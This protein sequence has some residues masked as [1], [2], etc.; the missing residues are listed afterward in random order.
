[1]DKKVIKLTDLSTCTGCSACADVCPKQCI[2]FTTLDTLHYYPQINQDEC[3]RC[4]KCMTSCPDLNPLEA[5]NIASQHFYAAWHKKELDRALSTSGGAGTAL[6]QFASQ[7]GWKICGSIFDDNWELAH[8]IGDSKQFLS[9]LR[10]SKYLQSRTNGIII[11]I[12]NLL[13]SGE[14]VL[15]FGT[16]CQVAA[17]QKVCGNPANLVTVEI[18]CHGVNSPIVWKDYV[19]YLENR[20]HAKLISYNF[21]DKTNGWERPKGGPNLTVSMQF[22][23]G[24]TIIKRATYNLFHYW[25]GQHYMLRQA[26]FNCKYRTENRVADIIIGDFWGIQNILPDSDIKKGVSVI[27]TNNWKGEEFISNID[28]VLIE[29]DKTSALKQLKG[30]IEKRSL[31]VR[32]EDIK[33]MHNFQDKYLKMS[34]ADMIR[35]YPPPTKLSHFIDRVKCF[36]KKING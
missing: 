13:K 24:P 25:F 23:Q 15:F 8:A 33:K 6:A 21:R 32:T 27:I 14:K 34:F 2:S 18:I 19:H 36:I 29:V 1:M 20:K 10:Q 35:N 17:V 11:E 7:N 4:G 28:C 5:K 26:C 30:Y 16:P 31:S 9:K 22:A 3:I 12:H